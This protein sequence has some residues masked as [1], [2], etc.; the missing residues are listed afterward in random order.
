MFL[1]LDELKE[2]KRVPHTKFRRSALLLG[3]VRGFQSHDG[4]A[5]E[6]GS[7]TGAAKVGYAFAGTILKAIKPERNSVDWMPPAA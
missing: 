6:S 3:P 7:S 2:I 4:Q 1:G 5:V